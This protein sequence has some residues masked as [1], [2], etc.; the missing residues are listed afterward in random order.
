MVDI[1]QKFTWSSVNIK[2]RKKNEMQI[3]GKILISDSDKSE[4]STYCY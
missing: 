2:E 3:K 4:K 1:T